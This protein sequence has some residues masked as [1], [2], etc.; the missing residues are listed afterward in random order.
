MEGITQTLLKLVA[1]LILVVFVLLIVAPVFIIIS[2]ITAPIYKAIYLVDQVVQGV[3]RFFAKHFNLGT[4]N[5]NPAEATADN[6]SYLS[7]WDMGAYNRIATFGVLLKTL[8][9]A[10]FGFQ[11][12]RATSFPLGAPIELSNIVYNFLDQNFKQGSAFYNEIDRQFVRGENGQIVPNNNGV[13]SVFDINDESLKATDDPWNDA[14]TSKQWKNY[15]PKDQTN[16]MNGLLYNSDAYQK[17]GPYED[18]DE[19]AV[20]ES[21]KNSVEFY[22][23]LENKWQQAKKDYEDWLKDQ[24]ITLTPE[25][26]AYLGTDKVYYQNKAEIRYVETQFELNAAWVY[27]PIEGW[28][29]KKYG[30]DDEKVYPAIGVKEGLFFF[31]DDGYHIYERG[32]IV[33]KDTF[34][35]YY[36]GVV[37]TGLRTLGAENL[38]YEKEYESNDLLH[39]YYNLSDEE[40]K[41]LS[42]D[43]KKQLL[44]SINYYDTNDMYLVRIEGK[45]F[46]YDKLEFWLNDLYK[47]GLV[48]AYDMENVLSVVDE[49]GFYSN[50]GEKGH[51]IGL[52]LTPNQQGRVY[53]DYN[54]EMFS[55]YNFFNPAGHTGNNPTPLFLA[56]TSHP[57]SAMSYY[58]FVGKYDI[59]KVVSFTIYDENNQPIGTGYRI[60]YTENEWKRSLDQKDH[61]WG[62]NPTHSPEETNIQV[63]WSPSGLSSGIG[64]IALY[65]WLVPGNQ[66]VS[67]TVTDITTGDTAT[68]TLPVSVKASSIVY[69]I[70]IIGV[71]GPNVVKVGDTVTYSVNLISPNYPLTYGWTTL[72]GLTI[73][74]RNDQPSV[75]VKVNGEGQLGLSFYDDISRSGGYIVWKI[76]TGN[77][78]SSATSVVIGASGSNYV[79]IGSSTTLSAI[80]PSSLYSN[81]SYVWDVDGKKIENQDLIFEGKNVGEYK[82]TFDVFPNSGNDFY[83][84]FSFTIVVGNFGNL[85]VS[86]VSAS[87]PNGKLKITL[88]GP[89]TTYTGF[90]TKYS[91]EIEND[92]A[93]EEEKLA[94]AHEN[95]SFVQFPIYYKVAIVGQGEYYTQQEGKGVVISNDQQQLKELVVADLIKG[96]SLEEAFKYFSIIPIDPLMFFSN[97]VHFTGYSEGGQATAPTNLINPPPDIGP[98]VPYGNPVGSG[99]ITSPFGWRSDP[100]TGDPEFHLGIDIGIPEGTP[101]FSTMDGTVYFAGYDGGYGYCVIIVSQDKTTGY[102]YATRYAHLSSILVSRGDTITRG[103][104]IALSGNT[105]YST[106]P[107]LHYEVHASNKSLDDAVSGNSA[108]DP[109]KWGATYGHCP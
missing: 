28:C 41:K 22:K 5:N 68:A 98:G 33:S 106:G 57:T 4:G 56:E 59:P 101:V 47:K 85:P 36:V 84:G 38:D 25:Q 58:Y 51:P 61:V 94:Y 19:E 64:D 44:D 100:I 17:F 45:P 89:N 9:S 81:L 108:Q 82:A 83:G 30:K 16:Y 15:I 42:S 97:Q 52:G 103:Q 80:L 92:N 6:Q 53:T 62:P 1:V 77:S 21:K 23:N 66:S 7:F 27:S 31:P 63:S 107:H 86:S 93:T 3:Q 102:W 74:G 79:D 87:S 75:T 70:P 37:L 90:S 96:M 69:P 2:L 72:G 18:K 50:L 24:Y 105:G 10:A 54:G 60:E 20:W 29:L 76:K 14:Q 26:A 99:C 39:R 49:D 104:Q 78:T 35:H 8:T 12:I 71:H 91:V 32:T 73:V 46:P 55:K 109:E 34:D 43:E 67:V 88:K 13:D 95:H 11:P 40:I 65:N 48:S